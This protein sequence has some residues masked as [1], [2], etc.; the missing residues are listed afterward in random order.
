[1]FLV[2]IFN[3]KKGHS[4]KG[5]VDQHNTRS[6]CAKQCPKTRRN[7]SIL[8][9]FFHVFIQHSIRATCSKKKKMVYLFGFWPCFPLIKS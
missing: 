8:L 7:L 2:D 4:L 9:L 3:L 6:K 5:E 1:M